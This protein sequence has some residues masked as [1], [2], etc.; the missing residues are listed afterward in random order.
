MLYFMY[1][2]YHRCTVFELIIF[3]RKGKLTKYSAIIFVALLGMTMVLGLPI[4]DAARETSQIPLKQREEPTGLV[5]PTYGEYRALLLTM[6][7]VVDQLHK[8]KMNIIDVWTPVNEGV[9]LMKYEHLIWITRKFQRVVYFEN[10][11]PVKIYKTSTGKSGD[12]FGLYAVDYK[13]KMHIST[14]PECRGVEMPWALHFDYGR[15]IHQSNETKC[16]GI[17]PDSHGCARLFKQ[18]AKE[19]YDLIKTRVPVLFTA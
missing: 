19:L 1:S 14:L 16:I 8:H 2:N 15:F 6:P 17:K 13:Q 11:I 4:A 10:G 18:D 3:R 7:E 5:E 12:R 9:G